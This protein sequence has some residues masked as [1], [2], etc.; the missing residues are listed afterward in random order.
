MILPN[1][2][3]EEFLGIIFFFPFLIY[4][5]YVCYDGIGILKDIFELEFEEEEEPDEEEKPPQEK[6]VHLYHHRNQ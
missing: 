1:F 5:I 4:F 2:S 3:I 6:E